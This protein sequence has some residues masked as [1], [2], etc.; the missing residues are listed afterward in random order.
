M[1]QPNHWDCECCPYWDEVNGCWKD[2]T[3]YC[4]HG[5]LFDEGDEEDEI[6]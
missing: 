1:V 5:G 4:G 3:E 6:L 2:Y